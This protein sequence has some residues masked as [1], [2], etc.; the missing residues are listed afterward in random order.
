ML[1]S[2]RSTTAAANGRPSRWP[3]ASTA[4]RTSSS[5]WWRS[6][7]PSPELIMWEIGKSLADSEKEFDRTVDYIKQTLAAL[8]E[9]DNNSSRFMVVEGTIGQIRRTP[10]GVVLCMGPYNYPLNE[11]FAT[12]IPGAAHGQHGGVQ[13]AAIRHAAVYAAARGFPQRVSQRRDQYRP[14]AGRGGRAADAGVRQGQC[15]GAD[16]LQ[17]GGRPSQEAASE[18]A[19]AARHPRPRCEERGDHPCRCRH[20][21]DREGM[22]ARH[23]VVQWPALHGAQDADRPRVDRR[24][25]P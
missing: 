10:L 12:L 22:P 3:I 6:D 2:Q 5:R 19:P 1:P 7:A 9:L 18:I 24:R 11:T 25:V 15:A 8:K 20:R 17:Q 23:A 21:V 16:R 14:R 13:A 4:C